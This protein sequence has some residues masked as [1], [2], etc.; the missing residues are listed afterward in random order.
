MWTGL[1]MNWVPAN[2]GK[3]SDGPMVEF[4]AEKFGMG[5]DHFESWLPVKS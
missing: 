4:Y 2:P 3:L 1:W 5:N